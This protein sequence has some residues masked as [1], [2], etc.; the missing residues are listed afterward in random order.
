MDLPPTTQMLTSR[1][2][3]VLH[4][5]PTDVC[6]AACPACVRV[7]DRSFDTN[8]QHHLTIAQIMQHI[9]VTD[10]QRLDKMFMCGN[11]GDPAAGKHTLEIYQWF[12][13]VNPNIVLGMNTNGGIRDANWWR[14][15]GEIMQHNQDYVVFSIDGLKDTNDI[16]RKGVDWDRLITNVKSYLST[17]ANAHWDMLVYYHN[18]HQVDACEQLARALGF[19]WFR[20]KIS[21]RPLRDGL[22]AP[23]HWCVPP[24]AD[25]QIVCH[26]LQER[27]VYIDAQGRKSP[28]CWLGGRQ[29]D[30]VTDIDEVA[31]TWTTQSPHPICKSTCGSQM[32]TSNFS[33]QWRREVAL[34]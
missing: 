15:L 34:C 12:R 29:R 2:I 26:A 13:A 17:G 24:T 1:E 14:Q 6:Q 4:L 10:I 5:E 33:A 27:S 18:E 22:Q 9:S 11:Y 3:H 21:R 31:R 25:R 23:V 30:F 8:V 7:T 28:C 32:S 20:A 16:Y 19:S